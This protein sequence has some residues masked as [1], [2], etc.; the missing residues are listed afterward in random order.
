MKNAECR[1]TKESSSTKTRWLLLVL[2]AVFV[3]A[4][5]RWRM[6][7]GIPQQA[8]NIQPLPTGIENLKSSQKL[9]GEAILKNYASATTRPQDDLHALAH[10]FSNL[11]LLVKGDSPFRM[12]A[13][14]EF[15]AALMGKNAGKEVFLKAPHVCLNAADQLV[16]RWG[17][18][19]FFHVLDLDRTDIRSAGPDRQM[20]TTDDLHRR[21]DGEFIPGEKLPE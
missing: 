5:W 12:G 19:L 1:M 18:P 17:S 11:R 15:V 7:S 2:L 14:E 4:F 3:V 20:W 16:D 13:N 9:P 10:A 8:E 21:H 6:S